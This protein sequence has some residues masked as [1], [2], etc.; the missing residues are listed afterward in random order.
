MGALSFKGPDTRSEFDLPYAT[1]FNQS[2]GLT[3]SATSVKVTRV[4]NGLQWVSTISSSTGK[5]LC[6]TSV[7]PTTLP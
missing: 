4:F 6:S 7:G 3:S 5:A 2:D 1:S